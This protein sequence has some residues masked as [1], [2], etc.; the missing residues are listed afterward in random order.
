MKK[1]IVLPII[2]ALAACGD[3]GSGE[4]IG[5]VVKISQEG[6]FC[7]TW[8]MQIIR[9][10]LSNGSGAQG[11]AYDITIEDPKLVEDVKK[12]MET[13]QEIKVKYRTEFATLCRSESAHN[14]FIVGIEPLGHEADRP[15]QVTPTATPVPNNETHDE[16]VQRLLKVQAELIEELAKK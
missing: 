12:Y 14:A 16:K 15:L 7:K 4:K 8:E 11:Q 3:T 2:L 6:L 10:G 13:Q 5:S 9:G 1:L